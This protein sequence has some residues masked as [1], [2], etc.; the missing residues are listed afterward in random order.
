MCCVWVLQLPAFH[1]QSTFAALEKIQLSIKIGNKITSWRP[2][3]WAVYVGW[4]LAECSQVFSTFLWKSVIVLYEE[5]VLFL[6]LSLLI[7]RL[8]LRFPCWNEFG[9]WLL[10]KEQ[11]YSLVLI[12]LSKCCFFMHRFH[13][14]KLKGRKK[15]CCESHMNT[16]RHTDRLG[17]E[18]LYVLGR[19]KNVPF[20][21][22][23]QLLP[24]CTWKRGRKHTC[25][26][27]FQVISQE[28][29]DYSK[30]QTF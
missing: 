11:F 28:H 22:C 3:C 23:H 18:L 14:N 24:L 19:S 30:R 4:N 21:R 6:E 2:W 25:L 26:F 10:Q 27:S 29:K 13:Y 7:A 16:A 9:L 8:K 15:R 1:S 17:L 20:T 5:W 12:F